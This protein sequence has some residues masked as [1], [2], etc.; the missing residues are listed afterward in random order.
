M[1]V[2]IYS[3]AG[4]LK[5]SSVEVLTTSGS[6]NAT[7]A[8]LTLS[9]SVTAAADD[10][11]IRAG[12]Y[13]NE[14]QGMLTA[15]DGLT[16]TIYSIDRATYQAYQGN[17][18]DLAGAQLTLDDLQE[19]FDEA[20]RRGGGNLE[21][22]FADFPSVRMYQK[23]LTP[24]KRY[25]NTTSGDGGFSSAKKKYLTFNEVPL[26]AD[27]DA[28]PRFLMVD[29]KAY[30]NYVLA[31]LE[32]ADETGAMFIAQPEA[33]QLEAR[34]RFFANMFNQ[35]PSACAVVEDYISP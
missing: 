33:D 29:S 35:K 12:S 32:F 13:G 24:D 34:I 7:T 25:T 31:E 1:V 18:L 30:V 21:A 28:S 10:Y 22:I 17:V 4:V 23:L 20:L 27:K 6:Q 9:A 14:I 16:T 15:E 26:I 19:A 3:S 5:A 8:T 2:D 11:L